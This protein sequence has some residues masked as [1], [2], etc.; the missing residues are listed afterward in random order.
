[1]TCGLIFS[2]AFEESFQPGVAGWEKDHTID[3]TMLGR[4]SASALII[5]IAITSSLKPDWQAKHSRMR[6]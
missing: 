5:E 4:I 2:I 3:M 6:H 1:M